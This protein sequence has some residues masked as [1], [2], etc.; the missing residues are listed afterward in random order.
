MHK[1]IFLLDPLASDFAS[2]CL[3]ESAS[4]MLH[5]YGSLVHFNIDTCTN[6]RA[7][8]GPDGNWCQATRVAYA[9]IWSRYGARQSCK[10]TC[11]DE[12]SN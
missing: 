1:N 12:S 11:L 2:H 10:A 4:H 5:V 9:G 7:I 8:Q 3:F 6:D